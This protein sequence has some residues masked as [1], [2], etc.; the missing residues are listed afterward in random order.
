MR[1]TS[2]R[3]R[4]V[5]KELEESKPNGLRYMSFALEDGLSFIRVAVVDT[6]TGD[7]PLTATAAFKAFAANIKDRCGDPPV[8]MAAEAVGAYRIFTA[9]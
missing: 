8:A 2:A 4:Q 9:N 3:F 7:N 1:R 5:F 6:P